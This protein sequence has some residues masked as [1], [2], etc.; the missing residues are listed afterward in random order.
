MRSCLPIISA[1]MGK[2]PS[3]VAEEEDKG[4]ASPACSAHEMDDRYMGFAGREELLSAL[5]ELLEAERAG[6]Q[7]ALRTARQIS[8]RAFEPL[9]MAIQHDKAHWCSVLTK[10]IQRLHGE[11]IQKIGAFYE[12]A[13]AIGDISARLTF[14]DQGKASVVRKLEALLRT[15]RDDNIYAELKA[16]LTSHEQ[17][18][19]L[20]SV[21]LSSSQ[22]NPDSHHDE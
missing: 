4:F 3:M 5:N 2:K 10:A 11:P 17:N 22:S 9:V 13:M 21:Q 7:V 14:L 18:I 6:A 1:V 8:D 12:Q 16:L 19:D 20:A 15:I